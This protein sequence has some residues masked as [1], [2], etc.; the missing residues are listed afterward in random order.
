M[1]SNKFLI[2]L[3]L[4]SSGLLFSCQ[5]DDSQQAFFKEVVNQYYQKIVLVENP[6]LSREDVDVKK[7]Y[8][9]FSETHLFRFITVNDGGGWMTFYE[10]EVDEFYILFKNAYIPYIWDG[11]DFYLIDEAYNK[12]L[13]DKQDLSSISEIAL[14]ERNEH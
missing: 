1:K 6:E 9:E 5:K 4:L 7:Y 14:V 13:L 11:A 3:L 2:V 8:G 10:I 12:G